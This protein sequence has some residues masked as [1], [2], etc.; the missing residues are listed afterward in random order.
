[1]LHSDACIRCLQSAAGARTVLRAPSACTARTACV[2]H[3]SISSGS[4]H[5]SA[6]P[7]DSHSPVML[8]VQ[9]PAAVLQVTVQ[10]CGLGQ[11]PSADQTQCMLCPSSSYSFTPLVDDCK[12]CPA[13]AKCIGGATL[14]PLQQWHSAPDSDHIVPCP[15]NNA[16]AGSTSA[17]LAC[18]NATYQA[19]LDVE[20][21]G[22]QTMMFALAVSLIES[23]IEWCVTS[24]CSHVNKV[25]HVIREI[26]HQ[27]CLG[28][29]FRRHVGI[30]FAC[31]ARRNDH[32]SWTNSAKMHA[33]AH[34]L[35]GNDLHALCRLSH[36][37]IQNAL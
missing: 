11:I 33:N 26:M 8:A 1:M 10:P 2:A 20:Q 37:L 16:C 9:V 17:L 25:S 15:N 18:Q 12:P 7:S 24:L 23:L 21:V 32:L 13:Q 29:G 14:V 30:M 35:Q 6:L 31:V 27:N 3:H 28:T 34:L 4:D 22:L 19:R 36:R 5:S